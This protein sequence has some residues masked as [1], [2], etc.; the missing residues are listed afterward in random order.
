MHLINLS[1]QVVPVNTK[2]A[3]PIIDETI[4]IIKESGIKHEV[5]AFATIMEGTY[6]ELLEIVAKIKAH[7]LEIGTKEVLFN[8]QMHFKKDEDVHF[9]DKTEKHT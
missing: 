7:L 4:K 8:I 3:Y 9:E 1:L 6:D 2:D 5:Q